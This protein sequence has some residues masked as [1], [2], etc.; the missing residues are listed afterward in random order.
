[1]N[2]QIAKV[3]GIVAVDAYEG[4]SIKRNDEIS[5]V[6]IK[7]L[8]GLGSWDLYEKQSDLDF[9]GKLEFALILSTWIGETCSK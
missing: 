2:A 1:M 9:A 5:V 8:A 4:S 6:F 7:K 3:T